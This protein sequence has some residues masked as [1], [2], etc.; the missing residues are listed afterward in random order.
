MPGMSFL[1][2]PEGFQWGAATASY[3]IEG[4]Y[5]EDD[6]GLSIWDVFSHQPGRVMNGENG[7]VACDHYHRYRDDIDLMASLGLQTYRFSVSWSR[8]LPFGEGAVNEKGMDFYQRLVDGLLEKGIQP[9]LTLFHWDLPQALQDK[10]GWVNREVADRFADYAALLYERLGDRVTRWITLN[11]P[12]I[13]TLMGY[14]SGG[15]APGIRDMKMT[16]AAIHHAM[17]AHGRAVQAFRA[18]GKPGEIGITNANTSY[19]PADDSPETARAVELARD[20]DSRLFHGPVYGKGYPES[21]LNYYASKGAPFPIESGD[22]ETI[23][24][25]TDFLGVNLY[26]RRRILPD[27]SRGVGFRNAP[28]TLPLLPMGYEAAPHALGDYVRWVTK[29]YGR[30]RIYITENGVCD[31]TEP[32]QNGEIDDHVRVDLLRGFLSGLHGAI[33]D[34]A[35]VRAYYQW[36][37]MDNFEWAFGYSK[38]FGMVYTDFGNLRRIPKRSASFYSEVIARN[39]VDA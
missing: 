7:D 36:S 34:G 19:E 10:G 13:F 35:D 5:D 24:Q 12:I 32:D 21:V 39:G 14:R 26:S 20:F 8:V 25:A 17:L 6:R 23:S 22:M 37:L 30:P 33:Q 27:D 11:E 9:A 29:E 3:Q 38:R 28:P 15:M 4:A 2:F 18:S 16:A 31:N 1:Q